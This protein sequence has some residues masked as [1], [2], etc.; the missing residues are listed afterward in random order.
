M[1]GI[2]TRST[3]VNIN[4]SSDKLIRGLDTSFGIYN[5]FDRKYW[6][7]VGVRDVNPNAV[8]TVNQP[9]DFYTEAGRTFKISLTQKF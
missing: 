9:A 5:L 3:L 6:N 7:A 8:S 4:L 1:S 2:Q